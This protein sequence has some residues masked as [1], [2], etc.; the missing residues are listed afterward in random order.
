MTLTDAERAARY[1]ERHKAG[2]VPVHYRRPADRRA[3]PAQWQDAVQTLLGLLDRLPPGLED[4]RTAQRLDDLL[5]LRE[6]IEAL[7]D[8]E[9]PAGFG[10]D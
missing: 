1:R 8:V 4:G 7:E 2:A 10:R 3:R 6:H 5:A 9:F